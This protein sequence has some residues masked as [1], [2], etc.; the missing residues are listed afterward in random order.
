MALCCPWF[1]ISYQI[2]WTN[3]SK[4]PDLIS[5]ILSYDMYNISK[6]VCGDYLLRRVTIFLSMIRHCMYSPLWLSPWEIVLNLGGTLWQV[7][8]IV[9]NILNNLD[10]NEGNETALKLEKA[11]WGMLNSKMVSATYTVITD[12]LMHTS[13]YHK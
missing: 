12:S 13:S 1:V 6:N 3:N 10:I 5:C 11:P 4:P 7:Y 2:K 8:M 9:L